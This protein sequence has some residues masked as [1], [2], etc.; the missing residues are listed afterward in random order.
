M[1]SVKPSGKTL[2]QPTDGSRS[3]RS[4]DR[5]RLRLG[6]KKAPGRFAGGFGRFWHLRLRCATLFTLLGTFF[7][8]TLT[9]IVA[10]RRILLG[11]ILLVRALAAFVRRVL[12]G[13]IYCSGWIRGL[14][15]EVFL[16]FVSHKSLLYIG[17]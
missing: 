13:R 16:S 17:Y 10:V 9:G 8:L 5:P 3:T 6:R 14:L 2:L 11:R 7:L 1:V 15:L 4:Q 12:L